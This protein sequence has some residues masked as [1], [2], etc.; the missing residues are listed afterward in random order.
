M[1][2]DEILAAKELPLRLFESTIDLLAAAQDHGPCDAADPRLL[3]EH[4]CDLCSD[5]RATDGRLLSSPWYHAWEVRDGR[6]RVF[7]TRR[8]GGALEW[9]W[10]CSRCWA[11]IRGDRRALLLKLVAD[12]LAARN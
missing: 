11:G 10:V 1:L 9:Y 3:P 4:A 7:A 6:L 2:G 12:Y 5:T 8:P